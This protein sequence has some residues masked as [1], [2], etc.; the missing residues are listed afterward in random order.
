MPQQTSLEAAVTV[1]QRAGFFN[2]ALP[3]ILVF[4]LIFAILEKS[5]IL[6]E[7]RRNIN[8]IVAF[9]IALIFVG[10]SAFVGIVGRMIPLVVLLIVV[11]L[12]FLLFYG[13]VAG[14]IQQVPTWVKVGLGL[15]GGLAVISIF[16]WA[17]NLTAAVTPEIWATVGF[18]L[19]IVAAVATIVAVKPTKE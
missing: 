18:I 19:V 1:L 2:I 11:M 8:A 7:G 13:F 16:L 4:A 12:M 3:F 9:V 5:Q 17:A 15:G 14:P 10:A 6:G